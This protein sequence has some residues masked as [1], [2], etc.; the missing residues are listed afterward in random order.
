MRVATIHDNYF[1]HLVRLYRVL[2]SGSGG[3]WHRE[4]VEGRC[5]GL[6]VRSATLDTRF[7][8]KGAF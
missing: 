3:V 7:I 4:G 5:D 6:G 8:G 1:D 2:L